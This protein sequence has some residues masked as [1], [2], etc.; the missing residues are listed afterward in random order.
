MLV[1]TPG[2]FDVTLHWGILDACILE[3]LHLKIGDQ[4]Y[5]KCTDQAEGPY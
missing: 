5:D 4:H 2:I 3:V 1:E